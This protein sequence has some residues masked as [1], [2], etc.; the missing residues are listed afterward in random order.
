[1][2]TFVNRRPVESRMLIHAL[3]E[4]YHTSL[5]RGRYPV[6]FLCLDID[7]ARIDVNVHPAKREI[8]F[9]EEANVRRFVISSILDRLREIEPHSEPSPS[10][11]VEPITS[12]FPPPAPFAKKPVSRVFTAPSSVASTPGPAAVPA[13]ERPA[14]RAERPEAAPAP[15]SGPELPP[16]ALETPSSPG[17]TPMVREDPAPVPGRDW[18]FLAVLHR[19]TV[20]FE[21]RAGLVLLDRRAA[22]ERVLYE[23]VLEEFSTGKVASQDLLFAV[24]LEFD[25]IEA[26]LLIEHLDL[27]REN[28]FAIEAFGRNF[29]RVESVP[30]WLDSS[31]VDDFIRNFLRVVR[32]GGLPENQPDLAREQIARIAAGRAIR[33]SD[34]CGEREVHD[35]VDRLFACRHPLTNPGG[36]PTFIEITRG[37]LDRRFQRNVTR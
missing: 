10:S 3:T 17:E 24:P 23:Q 27:L 33:V 29:F 20:L 21:T 35:L 18:R 2:I 8:R 37:E 5:P 6:A 16:S 14:A 7:P 9:R 26:A 36:R 11:G 28:G 30:V 19:G 4:S 32:D 25:S 31:L 15:K 13:P 1:M 12:S 22:H 34:H